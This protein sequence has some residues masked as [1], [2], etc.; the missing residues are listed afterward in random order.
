MTGSSWTTIC[1]SF[2]PCGRIGTCVSLAPQF[3]AADARQKTENPLSALS[4]SRFEEST[5]LHRRGQSLLKRADVGLDLGTRHVY[6]SAT[7]AA[8]AAIKPRG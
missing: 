5:H 2:L 4:S 3:T 1:F 7:R 8:L 6:F